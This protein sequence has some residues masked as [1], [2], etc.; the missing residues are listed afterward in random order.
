MQVI[1]RL[2]SALSTA[3]ANAEPSCGSVP[4]PSSSNST[5]LRW[6]ARL[7]MRTICIMCPENVERDCSMD[8]SSPISANTSLKTLRREPDCAGICKPDC[9]MS[10]SKPTVLS[11]TVLPPV[12]GPVSTTANVS[13]SKT[14]SIGTAFSRS[15]SGCRARRSSITLPG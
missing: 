4:A 11:V 8:C 15:S 3:R 12:F 14:T 10:T 2:S 9:A 1:L 6:F 13:R 7:R 5:K